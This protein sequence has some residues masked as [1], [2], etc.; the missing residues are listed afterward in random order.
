[1]RADTPTIDLSQYNDAFAKAPTGP[2]DYYSDIPDG[3]YDAVIEEAR[4]TETTSTGRPVVIWSLRI[5]GPQAADRMLFKNRVIT[6]RTLSWLKEDLEKCGLQL[7]K[8]SD[9][10][11]R[12]ATLNGKHVSIEKKSRDGRSEVYFRWSR[13]QP[14]TLTDDELPF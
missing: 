8:L 11:A 14:E 10:P 6:D 2:G 3:H 7:G 4:L 13:P 9:L 1:M 12:I 5:T